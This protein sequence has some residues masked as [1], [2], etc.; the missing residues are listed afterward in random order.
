MKITLPE[1][2]EGLNQELYEKIIF[3]WAYPQV[4]AWCKLEK[5]NYL[6]GEDIFT[7]SFLVLSGLAISHQHS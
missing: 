5:R 7:H 6:Q 4:A 2:G 3:E 1:L